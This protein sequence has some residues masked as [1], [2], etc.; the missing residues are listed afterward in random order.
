[1]D[2]PDDSKVITDLRDFLSKDFKVED[3]AKMREQLMMLLKQ[4]EK[5]KEKNKDWDPSSENFKFDLKNASKDIALNRK[6]MTDS[7]TIVTLYLSRLILS[8]F[9]PL[10]TLKETQN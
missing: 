5:E 1:M 3:T 9:P 7:S 6:M 4:L 8:Y 10:E 2:N